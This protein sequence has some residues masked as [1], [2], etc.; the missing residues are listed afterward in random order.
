MQQLWATTREDVKSHMA[1]VASRIP[2]GRRRKRYENISTKNFENVIYRLD[3]DN[4]ISDDATSV[5]LEMN[6]MFN[7]R[8]N[9][10][11]PVSADEILRFRE[12]RSLWTQVHLPPE[13]SVA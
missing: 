11:R 7:R 2:D 6:S 5:L 10:K 8:R 3:E 4:W 13:Q 1:G 12:L 9:R